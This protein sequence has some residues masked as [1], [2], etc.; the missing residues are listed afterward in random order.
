MART[1]GLQ[2]SEIG[3]DPEG[4]GARA[5]RRLCRPVKTVLS[6]A[7]NGSVVRAQNMMLFEARSFIGR[8]AE[9]SG[10]PGHRKCPTRR[11]LSANLTESGQATLPGE[12]ERPP[13]TTP[14][15]VSR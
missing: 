3:S 12:V 1:G 6:A 11:M 5:R 10:E 14:G 15:V 8:G 4:W 9:V 2:A 13:L 7:T